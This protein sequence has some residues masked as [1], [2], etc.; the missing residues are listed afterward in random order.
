MSNAA[1][2]CCLRHH[3]QWRK[4]L[5]AACMAQ[6]RPKSALKRAAMA[7]FFLGVTRAPRMMRGLLLRCPSRQSSRGRDLATWSP[8]DRA[9]HLRGDP[10]KLE[11][12]RALPAARFVVMCQGGVL[13]TAA[14]TLRV[15]DRKELTSLLGGPPSGLHTSFLGL[16]GG[17][18]MP[19]FAIDLD[20]G[21]AVRTEH[22]DFAEVR[23]QH[24]LF[25]DERELSLT[26]YAK[27]LIEWQRRSAFCSN[28]GG[29]AELDNAGHSRACAHG[30]GT[31][32]FPRHDPAVIMLVASS[33]GECAVL[34]RGKAHPPG[35][36]TTLAGF[37]E[38][39]ETFESA[40]AR[41]VHEEVGLLVDPSHT[42]YFASQPWPF[43][44]SLMVGFT[45]RN[46]GSVRTPLLVDHNE[47]LEA[48][49]FDKSDVREAAA[50]S[51]GPTTNKQH[52]AALLA[53]HP[54]VK[55]LIPPKGTISRSLID[56]WLDDGS[57][58]AAVRGSG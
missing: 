10:A 58:S 44:Q 22:A 32:S 30:C 21:R 56:H 47:L 18:R 12:M 29:S 3:E 40:V 15:V 46:S 4:C 6:Q 17:E 55:L 20:A 38:A 48:R 13:V 8:L 34:A 25:A 53:K 9:G 5:I 19:T 37:V 23:S 16:V 49:W 33:C 27:S 57:G 1:T 28:C 54:H 31:V 43:P 35:V 52:A 7:G 45:A 24:T 14:G 26:F 42:R 11:E 51:V 2:P 50:I 36:H 41:E 39:G